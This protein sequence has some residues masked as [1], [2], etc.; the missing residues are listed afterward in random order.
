MFFSGKFLFRANFCFGRPMFP[1]AWAYGKEKIRGAERNLPDFSWLFPTPP[2][3][4][5][6]EQINF[7]E[8]PPPPVAQKRGFRGSKNF[9]DIQNFFYKP[10]SFFYKPILLL[11]E[12]CPTAFC[13]ASKLGGFWLFNLP[14]FARLIP[15]I[16]PTFHFVICLGGQLPPLPPRPV[17][18]CPFALFFQKMLAR[19]V[20]HY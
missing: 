3:K 12:Y 15:N 16:C 18:L 9:P 10:N 5:F 19:G 1:F 4:I 14:L 20:Q 6:E 17:R 7:G 2:E 13:L 11:S 8:L